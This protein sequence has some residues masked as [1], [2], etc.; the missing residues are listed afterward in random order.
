M[1]MT[2]RWFGDADSVKLGQIAQIPVVKGIVGT[3]E[4][5]PVGAVWSVERIAALKTQVEAAGFTLDVIESIP[6]ARGDQARAA[7]TRRA[8]RRLLREHPQHGARGRTSALLQLHAYVRLDAHRDEL[9]PAGSP[10]WS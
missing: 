4:D 5:I 7:G 6:V 9:L 2:W 3:I 8:D 10:S 1:R